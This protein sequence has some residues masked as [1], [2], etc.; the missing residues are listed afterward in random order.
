[1]KYKLVAS[2]LDGTL[3]DSHSKIGKRN[4][5]AISKVTEMGVHFV[6]ATGRT[7]CE[8]P[9]EVLECS[10]IRFIIH[11][12]GATVTD[13]ISGEKILLCIKQEAAKRLFDILYKYDAHLTVR[14]GGKSYAEELLENTAEHNRIDK[15]HVAVIRRYSEFP[16]N[17]KSV[18]Y[19]LPE[20]EVVSAYFHSDEERIKCRDEIAALGQCRAVVVSCGGLEIFDKSAGKGKALLA[21][22]ERLGIDATET[23]G[24]GDS[25]NDI[26]LVSTAGLGLAVSNSSA[27][28]MEVADEV[29]CSNDE[30]AV[31]YILENFFS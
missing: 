23:I 7:L 5:D 28:L 3:L 11:S 9:E 4:L 19:S 13:R 25:G 15:N 18:I 30:G 26:T 31:G 14:Q 21:L 8:L 17:F 16:K 10:D 6:P 1:M 2:D 24:V 20:V 22:C 29:I 27:S 12:N